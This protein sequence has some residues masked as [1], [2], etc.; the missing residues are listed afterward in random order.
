MIV[1]G[2]LGI[3]PARWR[4]LPPR[5]LVAS[6]FDRIMELVEGREVLDCGCVGGEIHSDAQYEQT[7]H[8][9]LA[10]RAKYCL[11]IDIWKEEVEKRR[12]LGLDIVHGNVETMNLGRTF[13]VIV[14]AD[15]IEHL[16]NPGL[17]LDRAHEHLRDG[18]RLCLVTPNAFSLNNAVKYALGREPGV[19]PEHTT[20]YDFVTLRQLLA[21]HGF[22]P[23]EEY[24]QDYARGAMTQLALALRPNLAAH[25]LVIARKTGDAS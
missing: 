14:A 7:T 21:R 5:P 17:F 20:W 15:V 22:E 2:W 10:R 3:L 8:A 16:A 23:L 24:W 12:A 6:K 19:H 25:L 4:R 13:D 9:A 18:G 1:L 11:G